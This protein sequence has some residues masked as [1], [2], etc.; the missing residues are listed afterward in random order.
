MFLG[1]RRRKLGS[2]ARDSGSEGVGGD[3]GSLRVGPCVGEEGQVRQ[4][5]YSQNNASRVLQ[6]GE[7]VWK[8]KLTAGVS[9]VGNH[10]VKYLKVA[11]C[12]LVMADVAQRKAYDKDV[13]EDNTIKIWRFK[14][15]SEW[16]RSAF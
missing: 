12:W 15:S 5:Q 10:E 7:N 8:Q 4:A 2:G 1:Q 13:L 14:L 11:E 3:I 9:S 6:H 16:W